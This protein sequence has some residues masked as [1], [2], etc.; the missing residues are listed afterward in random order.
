M[1]NEALHQTGHATDAPSCFSAAPAWAGGESGDSAPWC[2]AVVVSRRQ[3]LI[4]LLIDLAVMG[5]SGTVMIAAGHG[6]GPVGLLMFLGQGDWHFP[7]AVGWCGGAVLLALP[8]V[9][10]RWCY[11]L[12]WLAGLSTLAASL[13]IFISRSERR[14]FSILTAYL[15]AAAV[16][17]RVAYLFQQMDRRNAA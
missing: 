7:M 15:F 6:V 12:V 3:R 14:A 8:L 11:A 1:Q 4:G 5:G 13:A 2:V 9:P 16:A 10:N 17:V